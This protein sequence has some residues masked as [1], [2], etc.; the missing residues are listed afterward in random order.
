MVFVDCPPGRDLD[1]LR[2]APGSLFRQAETVLL[3]FGAPMDSPARGGTTR[4]TSENLQQLARQLEALHLNV[5]FG[6]VHQPVGAE[7]W[8]EGDVPD[9]S[10][11]L[12]RARSVELE[13]LLRW[14]DGVWTPSN[15]HYQLPS[16]EHA[17]G[18]V[19]VADAIQRP[20]DAEVLASW[21][22][23]D[24]V[25][26]LGIVADT[27]TLS[28]IIQA[29]VAAL[30][31]RGWR[32]GAI[33]VLDGYP[34]TAFDV[35]EAVRESDRGAGI[36]GL[37]SVNS[38]GRVRDHMV[39]ALAAQPPTGRRTLD[40][41]V[42]KA[43]L[44]QHDVTASSGVPVR[45]WHPR[46][47]D[48][49]LVAFQAAGPGR[50]ELC[51]RAATATIVP[52][53]PTSFDGQ[54]Q[55]AVTRI[56]PT[57]SDGHGNRELWELCN[58][59]A[60]AFDAPPAPPMQRHRPR[61]EMAIVIDHELLVRT[62]AFR[63]A[64][65]RAFDKRRKEE[66]LR[67]G[68]ANIILVPEHELAYEGMEAFLDQ[69][70]PLLGAD[71]KTVRFPG[72]GVWDSALQKTVREAQD[73]IAI[74]TLGMVT[75]GILQS[76]LSAVQDARQPGAY[77]LTAWVVHAR[78]EERR[79]WQ[80]LRNS[81]AGRLLCAWHSYLPN[82]SP[83]EEERSVL[84]GMSE[85]QIAN[86]SSDASGFLRT[87][88]GKPGHFADQ[89][90][91]MLWG[92][93]P[94]TALTPNSIFGQGLGGP[95]VLVAVGAAM[96]R[97]R[98][99]A[100]DA[101]V[102]A[103]RVFELGAIVRS[104]YDPMILASV[105][106]WLSP[107]E[108]WWGWDTVDEPKIVAAMLE[109]ATVEQQ[110]ILIPELLLAAAQGK[111]NQGGTTQVVAGATALLEQHALTPPQRAAVELGTALVGDAGTTDEQQARATGAADWIAESGTAE[112]LLGGVSTLLRDIQQ[113]RLPMK[114]IA[115][116]EDRVVELLSPE[117]D[118]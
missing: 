61:G 96:E 113:G 69:M 38:S 2:S 79:S 109:R 118:A 76:V 8:I 54:L 107:H 45:T 75:G 56:T 18:F 17:A 101:A 30:R 5:F 46:P 106:R 72:H 116:L 6:I 11:L 85:A 90:E 59:R 28:G 25:D 1:V 103:R 64:A 34:S 26:R 7:L 63:D 21:L 73:S 78:P 99:E 60:I 36:L 4:P 22:Y 32:P 66:R 111:L 97:A 3:R 19:R 57:V 35:A 39:A 95:A 37:L 44:E 12:A 102:P 77:E 10:E 98:N 42:N 51:T 84:E 31:S 100:R 104:Y 114:L 41:L 82:R 58:N 117:R 112:E 74:L 27:G 89:E 14:G 9:P 68:P 50:C 93:T 20:R 23:G 92:T 115:R 47:G 15:Y 108:A 29:V 94:D 53:S 24:L 105:L 55:A 48:D 91:G 40:V 33:N 87:R 70:K 88:R 71:A 49:P 86:L 16:G 67:C 65:Y 52:V 81:Y 110:A 62:P 13:A 80:T 83:F 43:R